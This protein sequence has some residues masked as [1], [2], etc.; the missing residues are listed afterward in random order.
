MSLKVSAGLLS[1]RFILRVA[2][3]SLAVFLAVTSR[4]NAAA[5][6]FS[7][8]DV[9][10]A[11]L[12]IAKGINDAGQIVGLFDNSTGTHGFLDTGGNFTQIDVPGAGSTEA[13]GI[14]S[15]GQIVGR[16]DDSTGRHGFLDTGGNFTQ[17]DVPGA[18]YTQANGIN[19]AGQI[20]GIFGAPRNL[21]FHNLG[22]LDTG[23]S[24]TPIDTGAA[25]QTIAF[26]INNAGQIVG[27]SAEM[28]SS[29][30][31][32]LYAGETF[33]QIQVPGT[34]DTEPSGINDAGQI[35][36]YPHF[37]Y[38][39]GNFTQID[40]PGAD[41]TFAYGINNVGQ[42]VGTFRESDQSF[43]GFLATPVSAV[44]EPSS[45][46][47]LGLGLA[48][49]GLVRRRQLWPIRNTV[50]GLGAATL[51]LAAGLSLPA[52]AAY[53]VTFSQVGADVVASGDGTI[54]LNGLT[55]FSPGFS[56]APFVSST[57]VVTGAAGNAAEYRD[58]SG[59]FFGFGP[60]SFTNATS[61]TGDLAGVEFLWQWPWLQAFA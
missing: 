33:T 38:T 40:V 52:Q 48:G 1:R 2:A 8:I 24:F 25:L 57:G 35:V 58:I 32:F 20:V 36:G 49:L 29:G 10:G 12:T 16:F 41:E 28:I 26:G 5:Y 50:V 14:N 21:G 60:V 31:G 3:A 11:T 37:I 45:L 44:P 17:I 4:A 6:T 34:S 7:Q 23:G 22:F 39:G 56:I 47:L 15:A 42:I 43:H 9:P 59:P 13:Y 18:T 61:G 51:A 54:N 30:Q 27:F 53:T 46:L 19:D 55:V